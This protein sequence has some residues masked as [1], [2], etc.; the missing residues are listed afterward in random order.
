MIPNVNEQRL[1]PILNVAS[2]TFGAPFIPRLDQ[3]SQHQMVVDC[4][5]PCFIVPC[6]PPETRNALGFF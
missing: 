4:C 6:N 2:P 1:A 3:P 5:S